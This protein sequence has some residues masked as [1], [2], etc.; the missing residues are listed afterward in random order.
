MTASE[1]DAAMHNRFFSTNPFFRYTDPILRKTIRLQIPSNLPIQ[2]L[3]A[4]WGLGLNKTWKRPHTRVITKT[5]RTEGK[6]TLYEF[7]ADHIAPVKPEKNLPPWYSFNPVLFVSAGDWETYTEQ[8]H[9][10]LQKAAL[11][12]PEIITK[13]R[14]LIDG[15][16]D[17]D[18]RI[19]AI[20]DF[21][22]RQIE[23][24]AIGISELPL[25]RI[26][27]AARTLADGYGNSADRAVLLYALLNAAGFNPEYVLVSQSSKVTDLQQAMREY[28]SPQ[29]FDTVLVRVQGS[30]GI[31]YLNDT[32]EYAKL[33]T[34]PSDGLP[35]IVVSSGRFETIHAAAA[36]LRDYRDS[37]YHMQLFKNGD[38]VIKKKMAYYGNTFAE[39]H[40]R[41]SEMPPE[42][43]R[44]YM[45]QQV[46]DLNRGAKLDGTYVIDYDTYPG[47]EEFSVRVADYATRQDNFLYLQ[48]PGLIR[49]VA[50]ID[51]DQRQNPLYRN[52]FNHETVTIEVQ[53]PDTV[54]SMEVVPP[55]KL[56]FS[57]PGAG[58]I[59]IFTRSDADIKGQI[60]SLG[61]RQ[62]IKLDP[63]VV[64]PD[65]YVQLLEVDSV[66]SHPQTGMVV[67]KMNEY[68][69]KKPAG[70]SP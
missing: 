7:T 3:R 40:K 36:D 47:I 65:D 22:A 43:R 16:M 26:T 39:F 61:V 13:A 6:S 55:E 10:A 60:R 58:T 49:H 8:V 54:D 53:L 46:N 12:Q 1:N 2:V 35:G 45:Q 23:P 17:D 56:I 62:E 30:T 38:A 9:R 28:P 52:Y 33:G 48:L 34:T 15:T 41:F 50:D 29:W 14:E 27:P 18:S 70:P 19:K 31:V 59:G 67:L 69:T 51:R 24:V 4:D 68:V 66:L 37:V 63:V 11:S 42:K 25:D 21:V 44:R 64:L 5:I 20:R 57:L 32:D